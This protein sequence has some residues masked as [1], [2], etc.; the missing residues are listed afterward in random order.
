[1]DFIFVS[2]FGRGGGALPGRD[3]GRSPSPYNLYLYDNALVIDARRLQLLS[4]GA[5]KSLAP[6]LAVAVQSIFNDGIRL[7]C[8]L[9]LVDLDRLALQ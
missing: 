5:V 9:N 2:G 8:G 6:L 4:F 7:G 3:G 1:M